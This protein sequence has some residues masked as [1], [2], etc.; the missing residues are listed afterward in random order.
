MPDMTSASLA[1]LT[2]IGHNGRVRLDQQ[3]LTI[4]R[5]GLIA[6]L[7][8]GKGQK[9]VPLSA[10][11]AVQFKPAGLLLGGF[12]QFTINGGIERRSRFGSQ[13]ASA[14]SDENT[15]TFQRWHQARFEAFRDA[16]SAAIGSRAG[17]PA[18][19]A[20]PQGMPRAQWNGT[21]WQAWNPQGNRWMVW[22]GQGWQ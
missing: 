11:Q 12:I 13:T 21:V 10:I 19:P 17:S 20:V 3:F 9:Q 22:N 14:G 15:V 18:E 16:V 2:A 7:T 8:V 5:R 1:T 6:R 4:E